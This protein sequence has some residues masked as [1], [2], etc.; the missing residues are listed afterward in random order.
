MFTRASETEA[1]AILDI[2]TSNE[3]ASGQ[4]INMEKSE[5]SFIRNVCTHMQNML[6]TKLNFTE[7]IEHEKYLGLPTYIGRSKKMVFQVIQDRVWKKIKG[8][9]ERF[10]SRAGREVLI[11]SNVQAIPTYAMQCFKLPESVLNNLTAM[12]RNFWWGQQGEERKLALIGWE[13]LCNSKDS[14]GVGM[15]DL[16]AFNLALLAKQCWQLVDNPLSFAATVLRGKYFPRSTFWEASIPPNTSYTWR[17]IMSARELLKEGSRWILGDGR[18]VR[19][20]KDSWLEGLPGGRIL[21][22]PPNT[23]E[24]EACVADMR[25]T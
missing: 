23:T 1:E 9:K 6:Q 11:K 18:T 3:I 22:R 4:K 15:R 21:S 10:L 25:N 20:W 13:K 5:V 12:C 24:G 7:V 17:S 2:I 14:G 19:F 16:G 8:W